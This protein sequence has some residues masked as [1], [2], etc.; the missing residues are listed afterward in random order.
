MPVSFRDLLPSRL[1]SFAGRKVPQPRV[2]REVSYQDVE[3]LFRIPSGLRRGFV[4]RFR[5]R[6]RDRDF[7]QAVEA[8][9]ADLPEWRPILYPESNN[10]A[11]RAGSNPN[12]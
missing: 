9:V 6:L 12:P 10:A 2:D 1:A 5:P 8:H 7:R 11:A 3:P 4:E